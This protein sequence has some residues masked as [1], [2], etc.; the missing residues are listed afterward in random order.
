MAKHRR[1]PDSM[2]TRSP[3]HPP[4]LR[5]LLR[6]LLCH[7]FCR[8]LFNP[9]SGAL[10]GSALVGAALHGCQP[11]VAAESDAARLF[12]EGRA[13]VVEGRFAEACPKF[14]QSQRLEPRL[15]TQLNAAFC[16]ERQGD[17]ATAWLGYQQA[18]GLAR[19][20]GDGERERFA[21]GKLDELEP[22]LPKLRLRAAAGTGASQ[23]TMRLDGTPLSP[24]SWA[25]A[26]PVDP[27]EHV[28][29]AVHGGAEYWRV[30]LSLREAQHVDLTVPAP[31]ADGAFEATDDAAKEGAGDPA[32][33]GGNGAVERA[34]QPRARRRFV[35]EVGAFVGSLTADTRESEPEENPFDLSAV[36]V[37]DSGSSSTL[38]CATATCVYDPLGSRTG[39]LY[40]I[41]GFIG[42]P[43][44]EEL[45]LG[46]RAV[47]GSRL[48]G[49]GLVAI[50]P[51]A[52]WRLE[53]RFRLSPTVFF[54]TASQAE[55][56]TARLLTPAAT[57]GIRTRLRASLGFSLGLGAEFGLTL[58]EIGSGA[59]ILQGTPLFLWGGNGTAFALPLGAA[60]RWN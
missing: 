36:S 5:H 31:P 18:V 57:I 20:D 27:G 21:R 47:F 7:F 9:L 24:S 38:S 44:T 40:G 14:E 51:S 46:L 56:G 17:L 8:R 16:H 33:T 4:L 1:S 2:N 25:E 34:A 52:S 53:E 23:P 22:R 37:T 29:V 3:L 35:Y 15:G 11:A 39:L 49:G 59:V 50:G 55:G 6:H 28:V 54:G 60:Y 48:Y 42:H 26:V 58:F 19:R 12:S 45:D 13:L 43:L 32:A 30:A 10:V 41:A